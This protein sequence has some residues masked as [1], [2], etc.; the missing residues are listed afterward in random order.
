MANKNKMEMYKWAISTKARIRYNGRVI[1]IEDIYE[2]SNEDL[3]IMH[4]DLSMDAD[5]KS[6]YYK[7]HEAESTTKSVDD[8]RYVVAIIEDIYKDRLIAA[9][10]EKDAD[11][12]NMEQFDIQDILR[13]KKLEILKSKTVEE[14]E[15]MLD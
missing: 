2:M 12:H 6:K 4:G 10:T 14:L 9:K 3:N 8:C 15:A 7:L 5:D 11:E 1:S 13:S